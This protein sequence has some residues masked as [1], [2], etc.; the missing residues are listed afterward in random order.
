MGKRAFVFSLSLGDIWDNRVPMAW[1]R[2]AKNG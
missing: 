2:E 1:R